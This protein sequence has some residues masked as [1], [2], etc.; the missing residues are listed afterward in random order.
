MTDQH[1]YFPPAELGN[2]ASVR[3]AAKSHRARPEGLPVPAR[4][5]FVVRKADYTGD[6]QF[7]L[8]YFL[9]NP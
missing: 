7:F 6:L 5:G 2:T 3:D 4:H 9:Q 8:T 1:Y